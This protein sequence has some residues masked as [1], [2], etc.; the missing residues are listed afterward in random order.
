MKQCNA[1]FEL[2]ENRLGTTP[3]N[4]SNVSNFTFTDLL[5]DLCEAI[6][7]VK[8]EAIVITESIIITGP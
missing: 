5:L 8:K 7:F 3:S 2:W 1:L 4:I 6:L